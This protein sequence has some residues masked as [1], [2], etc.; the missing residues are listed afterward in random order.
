M[1]PDDHCVMS[2]DSIEAGEGP[3]AGARL[4][5]VPGQQPPLPVARPE[6]VLAPGHDQRDP[7]AGDVESLG[8]DIVLSDKTQVTI[9][10]LHI[11]SPLVPAK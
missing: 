11:S 9:Q 6:R 7:V 1:T 4:Q 8:L 2:P 10:H 3:P 5:T